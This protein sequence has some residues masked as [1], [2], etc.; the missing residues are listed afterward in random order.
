MLL[1]NMFSNKLDDLVD[2]SD[3]EDVISHRQNRNTTSPQL[4]ATGK[5]RI[6]GHSEPE[7]RIEGTKRDTFN[8]SFLY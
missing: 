8:V 3:E 7:E 5:D 6:A 2:S 4:L 1:S